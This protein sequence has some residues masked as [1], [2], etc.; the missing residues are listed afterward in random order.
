MTDIYRRIMDVVYPYVEPELHRPEIAKKWKEANELTIS[1]I[2]GY[3]NWY[4]APL[5][6]D[7]VVKQFDDL[8]MPEETR[9]YIVELVFDMHAVLK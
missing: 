3:F 1:K 2:M 5:V 9:L 8:E 4:G 7:H 6:S